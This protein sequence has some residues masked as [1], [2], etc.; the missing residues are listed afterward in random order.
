MS[1][2]Q[3]E[4]TEP[5]R[6]QHGN[7]PAENPEVQHGDQPRAET[8]VKVDPDGTVNADTEPVYQPRPAVD[9]DDVDDDDDDDDDDEASDDPP[10]T[11][12]KR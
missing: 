9:D 12:R 8:T 5:Q 2:E 4:H 7:Q 10:T 1:N 3:H 11:H 6:V